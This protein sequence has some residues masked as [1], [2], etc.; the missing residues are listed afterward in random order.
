MAVGSTPQGFLPGVPIYRVNDLLDIQNVEGDDY[1]FT[2]A[3]KAVDLDTQ[4]VRYDDLICLVLPAPSVF[5]AAIRALKRIGAR[6]CG[7]FVMDRHKLH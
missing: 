7:R 6:C 1:A 4:L 2:F 5:T 3:R